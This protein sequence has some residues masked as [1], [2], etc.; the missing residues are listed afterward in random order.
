MEIWQTMNASIMNGIHATDEFLPGDLHVR[1]RAPALYRKLFA[2]LVEKSE[3]MLR[4]SNDGQNNG[5]S[6]S[7]DED[8]AQ[9]LPAQNDKVSAS[10]RI[11]RR[12]AALDWISLYAIAVNEENAAG[13]RIVTA[14][15][16][17]AAGVIPGGAKAFEKTHGGNFPL[18]VCQGGEMGVSCMELPPVDVFDN[19][20]C[21]EVK[22]EGPLPPAPGSISHF[23]H[24]VRSRWHHLP[25]RKTTRSSST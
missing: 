3:P 20:A 6:D 24:C 11:R 1:R 8:T 16:N 4:Y 19:E 18:G 5:S 7:N 13:G 9:L 17:G 12:L 15:T 10:K 2:T 25:S 23:Y 22:R 21:G 14:P